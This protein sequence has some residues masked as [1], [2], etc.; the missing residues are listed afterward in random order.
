MFV[1]DGG[2]GGA[3]E[4]DAD[5]I[6][7]PFL[8]HIVENRVVQIALLERI[9]ADPAIDVISPAAAAGSTVEPEGVALRLEDGRALRTRLLV[10][11]D[12]R[13]SRVRA[14]AGIA[15]RGW[16]Y[17]QQALVATVATAR[18][19]EDTAWQR[20]L[21]GGPLAFLPLWDGRSSIVWSVPADQAEVLMAMD[22]STFARELAVAIDGRFGEVIDVGPRSAF[23]LGL[24]T[25]DAYVAARIA[26]VGDA[27]HTIHPL[28]GQGVNLGLLDA[29]ALAEVVGAAVGRG[30]D[31][32][33]LPTLRR[34]ERWRK[35]HNL[36]MA[37]AMDGFKRVFGMDWTPVRLARSLGLHLTDRSS[38]L[39][40]LLMRQA[41]GDQGDLP[42]LARR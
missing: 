41:M 7:V 32:G 8:G 22:R 4:F 25:V 2:G 20:F 12:G 30:R 38:V 5:D 14:F 36:A 24:M 23:P 1:W 3:I 39:K 26:L 16:A 29:A 18:H 27:A 9:C 31:P 21:P 17:D 34:Y 33:G 11:A 15:T 42:T 10:G 28:A 6:G 35:G 37:F 40:R 13:D 19:H